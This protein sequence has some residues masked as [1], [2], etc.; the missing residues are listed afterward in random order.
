MASLASKDEVRDDLGRVETIRKSVVDLFLDPIVETNF[1]LGIRLLF[2]PLQAIVMLDRELNPLDQGIPE[3][4][5]ASA[6][7]LFTVDNGL[8][9]LTQPAK[10]IEVVFLHMPLGS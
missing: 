7:R 8:G 1:G 10:R 3:L 6:G 4:L 5:L 9:E 2:D